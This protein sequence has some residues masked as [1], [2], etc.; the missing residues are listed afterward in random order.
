MGHMCAHARV[1]CVCVCRTA[2]GEL[3]R[4][5][6]VRRLKEIEPKIADEMLACENVEGLPPRLKLSELEDGDE[7]VGRGRGSGFWG[8]S[9]VPTPHTVSRVPNWSRCT[10][11][12]LTGS[13]Q[14]R[15]PA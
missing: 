13:G 3:P 11:K 6:W 2:G 1:C 12:L 7:L 4:T 9:C 8:W 5:Q 15:L 14:R 10:A